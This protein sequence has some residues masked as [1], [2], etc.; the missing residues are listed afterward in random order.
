MIVS[1]AHNFASRLSRDME[2][3]QREKQMHIE[4]LSSGVKV[5]KSTDDAG[6]F[7]NKIKQASELKRQRAVTQGLQNALSYTQV[8][9]GALNNVNRIYDRMA[10]LAT[11]AMDISKS[12][13]DRENYNKEFQ[14][15]REHVLQIDIEQFNGQ[16]L[17]RNTKYAV[18][19]TGAMN[20]TN[21]R[22]HVAAKNAIDPEY[23]HYLATITSSDEQD[24][25]N[26][27]LKGA[28]AGTEM[29]LGGSDSELNG[30]APGFNEGNWRWVEGPE[31]LENGG[32]GRLFWQGKGQ[33]SG[34]TLVPGMYENWTKR[35]GLNNDEPNQFFGVNEDAL[36]ITTQEKWNDLHPFSTSPTAYLRESD[37]NNL[38]AYDDVSG[39]FFEL[40][41]V[42]FK[43]FL[44]STTIDLTSLAN[45]KDALSRV[46]EAQDDVV[47]KIA[48]TGS[49]ASRLNSEILSSE[50]DLINR[51]KSLSRIEDVDMAI[52]ASRLARAEIKMQ[53]TSAI[54]A[55]A[56][57]LFNQRNYVDELLS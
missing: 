38:R 41:R 32:I 8:Q 28:V 56:N 42:S 16:D 12:D 43:R 21:A 4:K 19:N 27:Q 48:L 57:K 29:W 31:G 37:P 46:M 9:T 30:E 40:A 5:E 44:P 36:Q 24:E 6:A 49:N 2:Q 13:S 15:L 39:G 14:E 54:F 52:T 51:E 22:A 18:I 50:N 23:D 26:R 55:Q 7:S 10:Q 47:D 35:P 25:I 3:L 1:D 11:M 34:G 17:F 20:W 33:D 53:S 45:A